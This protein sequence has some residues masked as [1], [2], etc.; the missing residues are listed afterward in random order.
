MA[1]LARSGRVQRNADGCD[2]W[3]RRIVMTGAEGIVMTAR[4]L[5]S[6]GADA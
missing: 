6:Y 1:W 4:F 5:K 3:S 2:D